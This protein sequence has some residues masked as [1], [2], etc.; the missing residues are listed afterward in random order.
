MRILS[1]RLPFSLFCSFV[2]IAGVCGGGK[3]AV[4]PR[5]AAAPAWLG[6]PFGDGIGALS[7]PALIAVDYYKSELEYW[8]ITSGLHPKPTLVPGISHLGNPGGLAANGERIAMATGSGVLV[9][10][11]ARGTET[12][13]PPA[14]GYPLDVAI[15]KHGTVYLVSIFGHTANGIVTIY[16]P[17][18][19]PREVGCSL[20][21]NAETIAVDN[22][23]NIFLNQIGGTA[24][25]GVVEIPNGPGG[26]D[27]AKCKKL[28]LKPAEYGYAAG[29]AI[30]PK[31]DDLLVLSN[32]DE[33]AGGIE[34]LLTI[35]R[36]PYE[37]NA[38]RS[39]ELGRNCSGT[40]RLNADSSIVFIGDS[41]VAGPPT[42]ILQYSYPDGKPLGA[43]GGGEPGGF[44]TIP[45][46]LPN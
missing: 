22:E 34:G 32:P 17:A 36:K 30:D 4:T 39:L 25:V 23:G 7:G 12:R 21:Q 6:A 18:K 5:T 29:I 43:F 27:G 40:V 11:V 26:P 9:V 44:I 46:A 28:D 15:D 10:D 42:F 16:E 13:L 8:P 19:K 35:F 3:A 20:L 14:D 41:G 38:G 31:T 2:I 33:C 1:P 24:G 45:N 37:R